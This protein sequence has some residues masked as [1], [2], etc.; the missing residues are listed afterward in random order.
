MR[1]LYCNR[2]ARAGTL[3]ERM[4]NM[5][6]VVSKK[7][8]LALVAIACVCALVASAPAAYALWYVHSDEHVAANNG[9]GVYE[10]TCTLDATAVGEG[11]KVDTLFVPEGSTAADVLGEMIVSSESQNGLEA[12]HDYSY[13]PLKDSLS[14]YESYTVAVYN[15]ESQQPGT[16][17]THDTAGTSGEDTVLQRWDNVVIT[18]E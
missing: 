14:G 10:V 8:R 11:V 18:V 5:V 3:L 15:A 9:K 4:L 2:V 6:N 13:S 7:R 17:T 16:H 12:I 1:A